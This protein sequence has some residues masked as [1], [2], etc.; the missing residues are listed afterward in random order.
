MLEYRD[1]ISNSPFRRVFYHREEVL[2][3]QKEVQIYKTFVEDIRR[4][5]Y[6]TLLG[7]DDSYRTCIIVAPPALSASLLV[8]LCK[9]LTFLYAITVKKTASAEPNPIATVK[10][11]IV[12]IFQSLG[13]LLALA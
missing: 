6:D 9:F 8:L 10:A 3:N 2:P 1:K 4:L 13:P 5:E 11:N 12:G 7:T